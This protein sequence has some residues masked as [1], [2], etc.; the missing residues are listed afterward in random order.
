MLNPDLT[1]VHRCQ[2]C[3]M[4]A[5]V[6]RNLAEQYPDV[7]FLKVEVDMNEV[8]AALLFSSFCIFSA[9]PVS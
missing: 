2:P 8:G 4:M 5:P 9:W 1:A 3:K 6:F 7:V